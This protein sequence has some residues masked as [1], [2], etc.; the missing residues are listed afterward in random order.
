MPGAISLNTPIEDLHSFKIARLGQILSQKLAKALAAQTHKKNSADVTVEDLL[1]YFPMRYEDRS[2]PALIKDLHE[3]VEASLDLTVTKTN[4]Y[5]VRNPRGYGRGQLYIFEVYGIDGPMTG[6][7]VIVWWFVSGR[8]AYEIVKYYN[9]KLE[10]G[11]RFITFGRWEWEARRNTFKLRLNNAADELEILSPP[12]ETTTDDLEQSEENQPDPSLAAIHV[13]RR[14]P[15][16]RKLGDFNS[17]R[18]RE[19]VHAVLSLLNNKA[20]EETLPADL[21]HRAKL[22]GRAEA[23]REIHFP[24]AEVSMLDYE[25]SKSPA[26]VRMI[27]EDFFWVTFAIGLKRG[28]REK[29]IKAAPLRIDKTVKAHIASVMP[30][31]LTSAQVKV[32]KQIFNDMQSSAPMNRLLQ[33]DVGSGKTIVAVVAMMAAMENNLQTALMAPTEI[34]AEQHARSI[35]R[36]LAK[37]P[38]RVEL[39]TGSLRAAEKRQLQNALKEGEIH[40]CVGTQALIQEA[41]A[42]EKLGLIVIDEQHRFGVMQRAELRARGL[43]PDVLVMTATPI[44]RSLAMTV[45]GDL[46]VSIIDELPPGRTPIETMVFGED[47]RQEVKR[48]ITQEVKAGRQVYVVY[49]LVEE[50][51]KMD[52]KDATRR[53]EYLRD[54]VFPKLAVGLLHG[55]MKPA[56]KEKVMSAFV[57]GEIKILV[58]TT[59]IE[60][61]VDVPNA[62][63]M[64]VEHAERFGL[65]QLHQLRGR[66]GRGAEKSYCILLTSDKKTA[67]AEERL[68]IMAQTNDGFLIAEKDLELR[69]P[70]ELLGTKQSGLPEFRIGNIVR[71]QEILEKAKQEAEF[72]L[73]KPKA[74]V[75]AKM[76]A[77]IKA[78]P[79]FGLAAIG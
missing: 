34:L 77:R 73:A 12:S 14:V 43:N 57:A 29:E 79:R 41:V 76:M 19:I 5:A 61:G 46:D 33:G 6:R 58:S 78:D 32:T 16:Y 27:F 13:G 54:T 3:S 24:P 28:Q 42:F 11:T 49:P 20:I 2:R 71:D 4:G 38:Y 63:L 52:L 21:R 70:G 47:Q 50:S 66:V 39:L 9:A 69:G 36:L 35:K 59:V 62:S 15:V 10:R 53:Y 64:I 1:N 44:P 22:I 56:E 67:V 23:M 8:R 74:V 51:E 7:E 37:T 55:K 31:K 26:H 25:Q 18:V 68:G 60:V 40:A 65:S 72:Y 17:K 45:Y 48:L 75:T 30:F